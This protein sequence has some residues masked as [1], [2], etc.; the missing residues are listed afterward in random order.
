MSQRA[1]NRKPRGDSLCRTAKRLLA[2]G[3]PRKEYRYRYN[4]TL[5]HGNI[6][7]KIILIISK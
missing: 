7:K 6:I 4:D 3:P 2:A 5:L 1:H